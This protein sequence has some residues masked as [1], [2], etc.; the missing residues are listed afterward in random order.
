MDNPC[1]RVENGILI[2]CLKRA[3]GCAVNCSEWKA[4]T[5]RNQ[6]RYDANVLNS[7]TKFVPNFKYIQNR[8]KKRRIANSNDRG[9]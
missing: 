2:Q 5:A 4:H 9:D 3:V 8:T 7:V 1:A 6:E